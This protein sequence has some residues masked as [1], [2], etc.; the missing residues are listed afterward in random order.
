MKAEFQPGSDLADILKN[1]NAAVNV[2]NN[3]NAK[4]DKDDNDE[5]I[6]YH[7][8]TE[9][10]IEDEEEIVSNH[11]NMIKVYLLCFKNLEWCKVS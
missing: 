4:K 11:F 6:R 9:M 7:Q 10:I 3:V 1:V 5:Y 2:V 8:I